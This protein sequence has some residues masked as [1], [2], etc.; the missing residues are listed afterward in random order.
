[1]FNPAS[2]FAE[3]YQNSLSPAQLQQ[4]SPAAL[5]YIGDAVYELYIRTRYLLPPKRLQ[6]YH[7]QVVA[8]VRAE[9]QAEQL[10]LLQPYLSESEQLWVRRGRNAASGR[11]KRVAAGVYQQATALETLLGYLY[12]SDSQRLMQ[13]LRQ[14]QLEELPVEAAKLGQPADA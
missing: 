5:A 8:Q 12:L 13:L 11:P 10:A 6:A 1:M 3:A 9:T 7:Q 14:L 4:L 2:T